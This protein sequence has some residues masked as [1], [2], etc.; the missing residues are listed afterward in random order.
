ME[1]IVILYKIDFDRLENSTSEAIYKTELGVF[2]S[3]PPL[4]PHGNCEEYIS[5]LE[6]I[7]IYLGWDG[8]IYPKFAMVTKVVR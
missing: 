6:P 1:E 8:Q 7:K 4:S 2:G 5:T 3:K